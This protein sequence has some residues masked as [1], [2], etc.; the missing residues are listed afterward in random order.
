MPKLV[1]A[2][3]PNWRDIAAKFPIKGRPGIVYAY[4]D[5]IYNPSGR[6]LPSWILD[7]ENVHCKRQNEHGVGAWWDAYLVNSAFRLAEEVLAHQKEWQSFRSIHNFKQNAQYLETMIDRLSGP[8][9]RLG[10]SREDAR[11]F[12]TELNSVHDNNSNHD[13]AQ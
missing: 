4:G 1:T 11:L 3:P 6:V 9:Y 7:H 10:V 2:F 13:D 8:I 12:I 5:R